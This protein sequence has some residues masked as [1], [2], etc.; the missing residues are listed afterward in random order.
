MASFVWIA[1]P[2]GPR[3]QIWSDMAMAAAK[4]RRG[5]AI[6]ARH[7]VPDAALRRPGAL[8]ALAARFPLDGRTA[9]DRADD[10]DPGIGPEL[11]GAVYGDG[12]RQ[13]ERADGK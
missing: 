6:L 12:P 7:D 13:E 10:D 9:P 5:P 11:L 3:P 8:A 2:A 4:P 1:S